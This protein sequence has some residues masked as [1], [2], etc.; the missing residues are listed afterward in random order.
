MKNITLFNQVNLLQSF[1]KRMATATTSCAHSYKR[2]YLLLT[3]LLFVGVNNAWAGHGFF[4]DNACGIKLNYSGNTTTEIKQNS[5]GASTY[6]LKTVS[7]LYLKG[8]WLAAWENTDDFNG[9]EKGILYYKVYLDGNPSSS[10]TSKNHTYY[11]WG[12]WSNGSQNV[13]LGDDG[14][15]INI[16]DGLVGGNYIF[17]YYFT[18]GSE[19]LSNGSNNYKIS[20]T[21]NP[22]FTVSVKAG[23]GGTVAASSVTAGNINAVTLPKATPNAGYS[24][25]NWEV[26]TGDITLSNETSASTA[27]V[28]ARSAG[29]VTASFKANQYTVTLDNQGATTPGAAEVIAT[30]KAAMPSIADK[31]PAKTGYDFGGYWTEVGGTGTKYYSG[32]GSS[33]KNWDIPNNTTLYAC[34]KPKTCI[35]KFKLNDGEDGETADVK[36]TY[37]QPMP[38]PITIPTRRGYTFSGY[39]DAKTGGNP[40]YNAD[41]TSARN[42]DKENQTKTLYAQWTPNTYT[43]HFDGNGSTSG[44]MVD[45]EFTYDKEKTLSKNNFSKE[46]CIFT[47]WNTAADGSGTLYTDQ[48]SVSNLVTEGT[49]TLYAQWSTANCKWLETDIANI[50]SGDEVVI[51]M[52][53]GNYVWTI[54]N[55]KHTSSTAPTT[56]DISANV[57]GQY[58]TTVNDGNKWV[59]EKNND[60]LTFYSYTDQANYLYCINDDNGVRVGTGSAKV[61]VVDGNYLKNTQTNSLRYI[62]VSLRTNPYSWR[63]YTETTGGIKDQTLKFYKKVCLLNN[64]YWVTWDAR[65]G[66]F[67]DGKSSKIE[68][69]QAGDALPIPT[70]TRKGYNL[71]WNPT[72]EDIMPERNITYTALWT[73]KTTTITLSPQGGTG[74]TE[75]VKATYSQNMPEITPPTR[76]GYNFQGYFSSNGGTGTKYYNADGTSATTWDQEAETFTL[77]AYWTAKTTTVSF[78]QNGGTGGQTDAK[79]ATYDQPMPTPITVPTKEGHTF[80]GYYDATTDGTQYYDAAGNSTQKWN[81]E[82]ATFALYA[83]WQVNQ[84]TVTW[85]PN[86]GHWNNDHNKKKE[87]YNY[88]AQI[89]KPAAPEKTGYVFYGWQPEIEEKMPSRDLTYTAEWREVFCEEYSFHWGTGSDEQVKVDNHQACFVRVDNT[90]EW[91]VKRYTIPADTKYFVGYKGWWYNGD[92]GLGDDNGQR[93]K[94]VMKEWTWTGDQV[95]YLAHIGRGYTLGHA[96]GAEGTLRI[97]DN[98]SLDNL[99]VA[100]IP[101]GY[102]IT[103]TGDTKN[104]SHAFHKTATDHKWETNVVTLPGVTNHKYAM[105]LATATEGTFVACDHSKAAENIQNMGVTDISGG[106]K[107]VYLKPNNNWKKEGARFAAYFFNASGNTWRDMTDT[108]G[109][110]IYQC[111]RPKDYPNVIFVRMNPS[112]SN[113]QFG[114]GYSW[115]Q[116]S[117]ILLPSDDGLA[118]I[119]TIKNTDNN[120]TEYE[121]SNLSPKHQ[122]NGKFRMWDNSNNKNW[123]VHFVPYYL[124]SYDANKGEGTMA[125]TEYNTEEANNNVKVAAC[126]FTRTGYDF[127]KWNTAAN[128][129]G[130]SYNAGATYTMTQDTKLYAQWQ[131]QTYNITYK[132]QGDADFSGTHGN[133]YPTTHTY[134]KATSLVSPTRVGYTFDGWYTTPACDGEPITQLGATEYTTDITLYAKWTFAMEY[135]I[136]NTETIFITSAV[137]QKIKAT[138]PL[139]LEVSNMPVGTAVDISAPHITF[140]DEKGDEITQLTTKSTEET[141]SLIVAYKPTDENATERPTIKLSVL[142][143]EKTFNIISARSLPATFAIVAKVGNLWYALPSQ[144]L[145]S[146]TPPAA[147]PI[148]VDDMA[149]PRAVTAVPANADWSLRQVYE[150]VRVDATKD[151]YAENGH[152]LVFVNNASPAMTLNASS[153]EEENYL[154]TDAQYANYHET[155]PGLYE[156]TPTTTDLET[157]QLTNE[158]RSRTLSVNTA[159]V[160][161]VHAQNKAVE[162]VRFLPITG[163]YTPAA[164]QVVEWKENSVVIM[165]NGDPAQTAFVSVNGGEAQETVLSSAQRDIAVYELTADGLVANPTQRLSITIGTE[166]MLLPIPYIV[167]SNTT[168][169]T[170]TGNNK[171]LAAVSDLVVLNGKTLTADAATASKY[172]FRNVTIYGGGKL[173]IP[174]DKGFGVASFTLRAGG[175]TDAGEYDYV[176]PQFELRGTFTN[177]AAKINYDYIT[178]YDHWYHLVLPFAG[179]LTTI[180]YPTEFYGANV[181]ANNRGSWQI[182]R[183]AGEIRATGNYNAWVDIETE[184]KTSTTAGQGYIFWGAPKKVSVNGGASTRQK[185]GIQRITMSVTAPNAMTAENG[186]KAISELSSYANVPNNSGKDNDQGWNL[187]GNPYMV[188]LTDMS[189]SGLHACKLVEAID[190]VTGKWNGQWEWNDETNIRY[191]TIPSEHFDTYE[192]KTVSEAISANAL[193]PGRT[194]FV[195]LDGEANGITFA[196]AN[197]ASLM[198]ALLAEN[199]DK[200]VDIETGI[201]LSN[202]TLQDEVNFW[203]KDGKTND[204]EYNADY[205]KTPNNN[206]FNIYGVHTNGDLSW[207]AINPLLATES[208]P[209]GYQVPAAGTYILSLSETYYSEDLEALY[210]TDHEMSPEVTVDLINAPYEFSVNQAETNNERF[211]ISLKLKS[212]NQGPTTGWENVDVGKDQS[213]K[214]IHQ[215]RLYILRNGIIYDTTGQQIQTINK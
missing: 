8:W 78:D 19:Y 176:Y 208:M 91:Q 77:I 182:K 189:T 173:V 153:S 171:T 143:N 158:P 190:P 199:S 198:P 13:W 102:G 211:T 207:V 21:Y 152:N 76:M 172:T 34:W 166:K 25:L 164:L 140:Y 192:A 109:D 121:E 11:N 168:D 214:F 148:E 115:T 106:N 130:T 45:Q 169:A 107:V 132:D 84:Y 89:V 196:T 31:L 30:Y 136:T 73:L 60:N 71:T 210:V 38:T 165:Y 56:V 95:M 183:Y 70:P 195:Q 96:V 10:V 15:N 178:D 201:I 33:A 142:G 204:Y 104:S 108:D 151:R 93:S 103:I 67:D 149:D 88:G 57:E 137:G 52:T 119:Y 128:G 66:L 144:G 181:A 126:G 3:I 90:H 9:S 86:G 175:I 49:I 48:K 20:F 61:F 141:F 72:P 197:R 131:A 68:H 161:G 59:I 40:Y 32:T 206:R 29:T 191:L 1:C 122:Q 101:D 157:Y 155:N 14:L 62:G 200:P 187:I 22:T 133:N 139:T 54:S 50:E 92:L 213:I 24:F 209:I 111:E 2:Y 120:W 100:F 212:E 42:W 203:I 63:C 123:Y 65:E 82:D 167:N 174:S 112:Y 79:P 105:G 64:E 179:D 117:D 69:Y 7:K 43:V 177:S 5:S 125:P 46:G 160:F 110:G 135:S 154:L 44:S 194:F 6:A 41:G 118:K 58:L 163:R 215:D 17:E 188:N 99:D 37:D 202:E 27:T 146:T 28:K 51:A 113:N 23:T 180:K 170:L 116:T 74:G 127:L 114:D 36:A 134:D 162:Q 87:E 124:L 145:N 12:G 35:I 147:Y 4:T 184:D 150:A 53:K 26:T 39:F 156:W 55:E 83:Q 159:T 94:S 85:D 18:M 47:G 80:L 81:K 129:S 186:D 97:Y 16:L 98:T 205:P 193:V 185:W 138:P 75:S